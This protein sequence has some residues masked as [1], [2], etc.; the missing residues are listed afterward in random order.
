[1]KEIDIKQLNKSIAEAVD[2]LLLYMNTNEITNPEFSFWVAMQMPLVNVQNGENIIADFDIG[3][4]G[5]EDADDYW[6]IFDVI[7]D[8]DFDELNQLYLTG[9][10]IAVE[11]KKD[12]LVK[13]A[14]GKLH[15][16]VAIEDYEETDL[17]I[18]S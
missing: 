7:P 4:F 1:M 5:M 8:P 2:R 17:L 6:E 12:E 9:F 3:G 11:T 16:Y 14:N 13:A 15:I 10:Q 18:I